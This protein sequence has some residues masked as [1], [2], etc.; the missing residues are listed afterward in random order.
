VEAEARGKDTLRPPSVKEDLPFAP[1]P[2]DS[3]IDLTPCFFSPVPESSRAGKKNKNEPISMDQ[4][5]LALLGYSPQT[6]AIRS[7]KNADASGRPA[8]GPGSGGS[9]GSGEKRG[10]PRDARVLGNFGFKR[11]QL[12]SPQKTPQREERVIVVL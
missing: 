12:V 4:L 3:P 8:S 1:L 6:S 11:A 2:Y 9:G 5:E 7:M 10:T